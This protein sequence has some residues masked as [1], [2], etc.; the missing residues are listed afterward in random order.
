MFF[1]SRRIPTKT[2]LEPVD[3]MQLRGSQT[4]GQASKTVLAVFLLLL[5]SHAVLAQ[6]LASDSSELP[7][8][9]SGSDLISQ[10]VLK[11]LAGIEIITHPPR[12]ERLE[13]LRVRLNGIL[14]YL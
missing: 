10:P 4:I 7:S 2:E 3:A 6:E 9:P 5:S 1:I 11:P 8:T 13:V 14:L 12:P